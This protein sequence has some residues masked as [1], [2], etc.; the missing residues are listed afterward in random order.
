MNESQQI[1]RLIAMVQTAH[2]ADAAHMRR[3]A[4]SRHTTTAVPAP[5]DR[6]WYV[7]PTPGAPAVVRAPRAADAVAH[8]QVA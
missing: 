5:V 3:H 8:A 7:Q 1:V 2:L 6:A 4:R